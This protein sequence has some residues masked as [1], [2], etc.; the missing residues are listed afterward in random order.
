VMTR[1]GVD[2]ILKFAFN[3]AQRRE[4]KH[5]TSATKSNGISIT[6]PFWDERVSRC[7]NPSRASPGTNFTSNPHRNRPESIPDHVVVALTSSFDLARVRLNHR[8]SALRQHQ[9][10][11]PLPISLRARPWLRSRHRRQGHRKSNRPDMVSGHDARSPRR[12]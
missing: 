5:L 2:R 4:K 8:H 7:P 3:L 6:M 11:T 1:V 12:G 10:R 9:P